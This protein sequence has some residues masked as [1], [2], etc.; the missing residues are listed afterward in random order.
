MATY[1]PTKTKADLQDELAEAQDYIE[2][3]E[4]KLDNI[5]GIATEEDDLEDSE[6][7]DS[8]EDDE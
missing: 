1:T 3:L 2:E 4:S 7:S 6:D 8:D 5:V